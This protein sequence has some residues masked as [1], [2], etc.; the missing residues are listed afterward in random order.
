[1]VLTLQNGFFR[2][3]I[4]GSFKAC[5]TLLQE[6]PDGG[7]MMLGYGCDGPRTAQRGHG[8]DGQGIILDSLLGVTGGS[9]RNQRGRS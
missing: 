6:R 8:P 3:S 4:R 7:E 9:T 1:M 5:K 2:R